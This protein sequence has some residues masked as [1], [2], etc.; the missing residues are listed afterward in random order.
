[1]PFYVIAGSTR[2]LLRYWVS[3]M[4][5]LRVI[6]RNEA[7]QGVSGSLDCFV[8]PPRN[9]AKRVRELI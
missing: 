6:A 3:P 7:I 5:P 9:D 2:N 4:L 8:V 1:M